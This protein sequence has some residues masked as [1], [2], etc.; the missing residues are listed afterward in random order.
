M[1]YAWRLLRTVL[2]AQ[3]PGGA[4]IS[5]FTLALGEIA[6]D[7]DATVASLS[8]AIT[9]SILASAIS[10][11]ICGKLGDMYGHKR[12]YTAAVGVLTLASVGS[13]FSWNGPSLIV[14]R[15][16]AGLGIGASQ[17]TSSAMVLRAFPVAERHKVV[18]W[19]QSATTIFPALGLLVGGPAIDAIGW[20]PVFAI[21]A[22]LA[23]VG[24]AVS[25]VVIRPT[26]A[27]SAYRIDYA[28]A[29]LL[30]VT[31][32]GL[33]MY[34]D[35][36][37]RSGFGATAPL[38]CLIT[39]L[40]GAALFVAVERRVEQPLIRLHY[41]A[42][43]N[44]VVPSLLTST[45]NYAF[46]GGL[47]VAPLLLSDVFGFSNS[48]SSLYLFLRPLLYSGAALCAGRLYQ[49]LGERTTAV[50]GSSMMVGSMLLFALAASAHEPL[51][52]LVALLASGAGFGIVSPA[53]AATIA[54]ATDP[55][56]YGVVSGM[57]NTISQV[58][59][60]A[61]AQTMTVMLG[62]EHTARAFVRS[63]TLGAAVCAVGVALA[64]FVRS[65][66]RRVPSP[67]RR[68]RDVAD[69]TAATR[70]S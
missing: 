64:W 53:M 37:K 59:V 56:D 34:F 26:E 9:G 18:G 48:K 28:G 30:A 8:W 13:V 45:L 16:I 33:L 36:G 41:F 2:I 12:V 44:F 69:M 6:A 39:G 5:I 35:R 22:L 43:R 4:S 14:F 31:V 63:F 54:N 1:A 70:V 52:V 17:A 50:A 10:A 3:L 25:S 7:L 32:V 11:S 58:G 42:Q 29:V 65:T 40:V 20:R 49:L 46:M 61:G 62:D 27:G 66:H 23:L 19:H 47:V 57:R 60:T 55:A 38:A 67:A 51:L 24:L 15:C 21:F 68:G